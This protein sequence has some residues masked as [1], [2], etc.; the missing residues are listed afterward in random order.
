MNHTL[1]INL[2]ASINTKKVFNLRFLKFFSIALT[3]SLVFL[4][5][6]QVNMMTKETALIESYEF[7]AD[8]LFKENKKLE[9]VFSQK[10][11]LRNFDDILEKMEFEKL[12]E[13]DYIQILDI[14]VAAK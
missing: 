6:F 14:S 5:V 13:V 11:S 1:S 7:E 9:I 4:C 10:N 8:Q 2:P 12:V 3:I